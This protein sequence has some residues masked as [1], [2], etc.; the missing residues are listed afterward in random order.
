[1]EQNN[2][3]LQ[4]HRSRSR[5]ISIVLKQQPFSFQAAVIYWAQRKEVSLTSIH[6]HPEINGDK[7]VFC[8]NLKKRIAA[9]LG[10]C[11][12]PNA[13]QQGHGCQQPAGHHQAS[14][15]EVHVGEVEGVLSPG[16]IKVLL[17]NMPIRILVEIWLVNNECT[18]VILAPRASM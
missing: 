4:W 5:N 6:I 14:R 1:M 7:W 18:S 15:I 17:L 16:L 10:I 3:H 12:S 2:A 9:S 11:T 13:Q 8:M